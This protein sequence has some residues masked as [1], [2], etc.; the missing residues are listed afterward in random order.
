MS[1]INDGAI[2]DAFDA[3]SN[4]LDLFQ[5]SS[6][7]QRNELDTSD[8]HDAID[9][10]PSLQGKRLETERD[11]TATITKCCT[12]RAVKLMVYCMYTAAVLV[13]VAVLIVKHCIGWYL[14]KKN[15]KA[16]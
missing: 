13:F 11:I 5:K 14:N 2:P 12:K 16:M 6:V 4:E 1:Q 9:S 3:D 7:D 15:S 10:V 8:K